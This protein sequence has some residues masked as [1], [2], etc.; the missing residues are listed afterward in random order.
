[1]CIPMCVYCVVYTS[2]CVFYNM[3]VPLCVVQ[4][5][6]HHMEAFSPFLYN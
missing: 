1:M 5:A 2:L 6:C 4:Y 3:R